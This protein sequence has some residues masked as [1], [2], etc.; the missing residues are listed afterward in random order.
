M[1]LHIYVPDDHGATEV[2]AVSGDA[3]A[4]RP[5]RWPGDTYPSLWF[6]F[7]VRNDT[8][9]AAPAA[10]IEVR[11]LRPGADSY[12]PFWKHC[13][14][15]RDGEAW[16]RIP[17]GCQSFGETTLR[18]DAPLAVGETVWVAATFPLSYA[19]CAARS[20]AWQQPAPS[21]LT[22]E[23]REFGRSVEGRPLEAFHIRRPGAAP[24]HQFVIVA[25]QHAVEQTGKLFAR[26]VLDGYHSGAFANTPMA[27]LLE[28]WAVT[29][30]P[31]ANPDGCAHG[32]MNTNAAGVVVDDPAD[33]SVE[34][35]A[36]LGLLDELQPRVLVNCH[37]WGNE[38]GA[39]PYED[40]YRWTD[41]DPLFAWLRARVP[42]CN[43][44][45][46]AHWLADR[47]RL[48]CH[49]RPRYGT[50]CVITEQ[51]WNWYVPPSGG[52]PRHPTRA[53]LE[54]RVVEYFTEMA[55]FCLHG[56]GADAAL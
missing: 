35:R 23:R 21:G 40:L 33:D 11:E 48:E 39:P 42:G 55:C 30:V 9:S 17:D 47:F 50:E 2:L 31:L 8:N 45:S 28:Q 10:R 51:N 20:A 22:L 52:P 44:S 5:R 49:V 34:T 18:I 4:V 27:A 46:A 54:V 16:E 14:W 1:P 29:V 26:V 13:L 32:R 56:K 7:A 24:E 15:S 19:G 38:Q 41:E 3:V 37:G 25:G 36:L 12:E 53:D 43:S 6:W